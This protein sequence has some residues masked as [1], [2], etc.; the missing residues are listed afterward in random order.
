MLSLISTECSQNS[1]GSRRSGICSLFLDSQTLLPVHPL[2]YY[3]FLNGRTA[4]ELIK[5]LDAYLKFSNCLQPSE[6]SPPSLVWLCWTFPPFEPTCLCHIVQMPC[7]PQ[8][9]KLWCGGSCINH[10]HFPGPSWRGQLLLSHST[11]LFQRRRLKDYRQSFQ[12]PHFKCVSTGRHTLWNSVVQLILST[13]FP[14]T[15]SKIN[16]SAMGRKEVLCQVNRWLIARN[17]RLLKNRFLAGCMR[18]YTGTIPCILHI[19]APGIFVWVWHSSIR[20][21]KRSHNLCYTAWR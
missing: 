14:T 18:F 13:K 15:S 4:N 2:M 5:F 11:F 12:N 16:L 1:R 10:S 17:Q 19:P 9:T 6:F 20:F 7:N 21:W 3:Q 8:H